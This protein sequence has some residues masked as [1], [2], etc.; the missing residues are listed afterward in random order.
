MKWHRMISSFVPYTK[1]RG[2]TSFSS[3]VHNKC[4][5]KDNCSGIEID[6]YYSSTYPSF[7]KPFKLHSHLSG[8]PQYPKTETY[9]DRAKIAFD[10]LAQRNRTWK[11]L[12]PIVN[13]AC[14]YDDNDDND[15]QTN[16]L[17]IKRI[18]DIGCDHGLLA[19]ALALSN[20]FSKNIGIDVS[21][22]ALHN[23]AIQ[24]W[25]RIID[26]CNQS[27]HD[28]RLLPSLDF[29]H[30]DGLLP[31]LND[32]VDAL[33][34]AGMGINTMIQILYQNYVSSSL[35]LTN[36]KKNKEV[37]RIGCKHLF[38]QPTNSRPR[39]LIKLY[40]KLQQDGW[41]LKQEHIVILSSRWYITSHFVLEDDDVGDDK[42]GMNHV[43][44]DLLPGAI[45]NH[46]DPSH[47]MYPIYMDYIQ[48]HRNWLK[49]DETEK[50]ILSDED[51]RWLYSLT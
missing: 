29:R 1:I 46:L 2:I 47:T 8:D 37:Y 32:E 14:N 41:K 6:P 20:K 11:R 33:C 17:T 5:A 25:N 50:R 24:N 31:L 36:Q 19:I 39:N 40:D 10:T 9:E 42:H 7:E 45:L 26:Y 49:K 23:G 12:S 22:T 18:A 28:Q 38:L 30:G 43:R 15:D 51:K 48:H 34:M 44:H 21:E 3:I 16:K 4:I 35:S 13:M 27:N